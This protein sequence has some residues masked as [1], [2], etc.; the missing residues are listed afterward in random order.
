MRKA[1]LQ[2]Q[3]IDAR[4]KK[5]CRL[6]LKSLKRNELLSVMGEGQNDRTALQVKCNWDEI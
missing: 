5:E 2:S 4:L 6:R 1:Q 3:L